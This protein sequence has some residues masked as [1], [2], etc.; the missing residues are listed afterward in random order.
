MRSILNRPIALVDL[1][2]LVDEHYPFTKD[3]H[4]N[5]QRDPVSNE[6]L[7]EAV[8]QHTLNHLSKSTIGPIAAVL[9]A[10]DHGKEID[11]T[12]HEDILIALAK[13]LVN[14]EKMANTLGSSLH[15]VLRATPEAMGV[16]IEYE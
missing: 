2:S 16:K 6:V 13:G 11:S 15:S 9:E 1:V 14:M 5:L 12:G 3:T 8:I 10:Y 7:P 4:P